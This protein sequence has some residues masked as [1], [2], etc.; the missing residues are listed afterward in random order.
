MLIFF[1]S[2]F[3]FERGAIFC[4]KHRQAAECSACGS[5]S[6]TLSNV[7]DWHTVGEGCVAGDCV[8]KSKC[9][10]EKA[11]SQIKNR[12]G[13]I[14]IIQLVESPGRNVLFV[15]YKQVDNN[16]ENTVQGSE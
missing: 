4:P 14:M 16:E 6:G 15:C 10:C 1:C 11:A 8:I 5:D 3:L 7:R 2:R 12:K 13:R 9:N